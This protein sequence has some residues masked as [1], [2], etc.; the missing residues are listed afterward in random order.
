MGRTGSIHYILDKKRKNNG[1]NEKHLPPVYDKNKEF[2]INIRYRYKKKLNISTGVKCSIKNYNKNYYVKSKR[3][4]VLKTDK[5]WREKNKQ[6]LN[7]TLEIQSI[8]MMLDK[9]GLEPTKDNVKSKLREV[10]VERKIKSY[11]NIHLYILF[12]EYSDWV[13]SNQFDKTKSYKRTL[14]VSIR[15]VSEFILYYESNH[16]FRLML[17]DID[18]DWM[19]KFILW[20]SKDGIQPI[21]IRKRCKT[22]VNFGNWCRNRKGLQ[23]NIRIPKKLKS[24]VDRKPIYLKSTEV[25]KLWEFDEFNYSNP[26]HKTHL[27]FNSNQ[28]E[29]IIDNSVKKNKKPNKFTNWEVYK[30]MMVFLC[31]SGMRYGDMI[32]LKWDNFEYLKDKK[33]KDIRNKGFLVFRMEKTNREVVL[34]VN[35]TLMDIMIKY[36]KNKSIED[37]IFPR[38]KFGNGI[39]NQI[40]NS[41]IK[42]ISKKIGLNRRVRKPKFHINGKII[43]GTNDSIPLYR[44]ISS[45]IGRKSYIKQQVVKG[46]PFEKIKNQTGHQSQQVFESYFSYDKEDLQGVNHLM[47]STDLNTDF[48]SEKSTPI[49]KEKKITT[50]EDLEFLEKLNKMVGK[51]ITKEEFNTI[52]KDRLGF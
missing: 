23:H 34:D 40:F 7:K 10:E 43:D 47:Y 50:I 16:K 36:V 46:I 5:N 26:K 4:P 13:N 44:L 28:I 8:V 29:Y 42:R 25:T 38:T 3:E 20:C 17:V 41:H 19:E 21:T 31:N 6:I 35:Q 51:S 14:N 22:L 9:S 2:N 37:Y 27:T 24:K 39:S 18:D 15:K 11:D 49:P 12:K 1:K 48:K 52:K 30:D 32:N 45:H 33:G